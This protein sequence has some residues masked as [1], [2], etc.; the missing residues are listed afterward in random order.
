MQ[1]GRRSQNTAGRIQS[2]PVPFRPNGSGCLKAPIAVR[3]L[4]QLLLIELRIGHQAGIAQHAAGR[5]YLSLLG[6]RE[7]STA[8]CSWRRNPQGLGP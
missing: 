2:S 8:S 4:L 5:F 7:T 3:Q 1:C 6:W